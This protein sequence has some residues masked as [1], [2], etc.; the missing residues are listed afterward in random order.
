[1]FMANN[2]DIVFGDLSGTSGIIK[3]S[4]MHSMISNDDDDKHRRI[5]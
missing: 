3:G 4:S 5:S 2:D 1:M